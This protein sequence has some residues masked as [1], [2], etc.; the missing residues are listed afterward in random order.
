MAQIEIPNEAVIARLG[1][2][3]ADALTNNAKLQVA[4]DSAL[5]RIDVLEAHNEELEELTVTKQEA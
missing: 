4:L 1:A 5:S 2:Q 3:L